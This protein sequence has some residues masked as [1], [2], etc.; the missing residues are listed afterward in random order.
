MNGTRSRHGEKEMFDDAI[1]DPA[2]NSNIALSCQSESTGL[3]DKHRVHNRNRSTR[4]WMAQ[5]PKALRWHSQTRSCTCMVH[6]GF[7]D[8]DD[9][10]V[11]A[12]RHRRSA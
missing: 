10:A 11:A 6:F 9:R 4:W 8:Q 5:Y 1:A 2:P 3:G 7:G 12:S